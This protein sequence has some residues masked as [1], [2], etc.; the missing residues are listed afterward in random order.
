MKYEN[1]F[2]FFGLD[3]KLKNTFSRDCLRMS[4]SLNE[5]VCNVILKNEME[6]IETLKFLTVSSSHISF[7]GCLLLF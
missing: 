4:K 2:F 7:G 5:Y 6:Y 3:V 1:L